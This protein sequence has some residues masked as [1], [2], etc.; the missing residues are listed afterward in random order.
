M[1]KELIEQ[2]AKEFHPKRVNNVISAPKWVR[3]IA[4]YENYLEDFVKKYRKS[5]RFTQRGDAYVNQIIQSHRDECKKLGYT[6]ISQHDSNSG[7][8]VAY[9]PFEDE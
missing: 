8:M 5:E 2:R 4:K 3:E 7:E 1:G 6:T 9:I